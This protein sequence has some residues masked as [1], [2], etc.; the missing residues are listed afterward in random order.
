MSIKVAGVKDVLKEIRQIDPEIRRQFTRDAKKIA[1]PIMDTAKAN[2]PATALSGMRF[3]WTQNK[4]QLLP[5]NVTMAKRGVQLKVDTSKRRQSVITVIQKNPA[6]AIIEF[7]GN[8]NRFGRSLSTLA[9]GTP[10]RVMWK[11]AD[12]RTEQ[13]TG[14]IRNLIDTVA[15]SVN[16]KLVY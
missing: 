13:V 8:T 3:S 9:W 10:G 5:W 2:Y 15:T 12:G 1:A 11:A 6:A 4:R 14:E 16:R 7:A